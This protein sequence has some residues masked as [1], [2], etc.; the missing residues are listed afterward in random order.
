MVGQLTILRTR[1]S[2]MGE[3]TRNLEWRQRNKEY[4]DADVLAQTL[5]ITAD[6][7]EITHPYVTLDSTA[8]A[9]TLAL[10]NGEPGQVLIVDHKTDG[11]DVDLTPVLATGWSVIALD[12]AGDK[13]ILLYVNDDAGWVIIGLAGAT[14]APL[15]TAA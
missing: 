14:A 9:V 11:G 7:V 6:T 12:D 13:A 3:R 8:G 2:K 4:S 5:V 10:P 15:F 1:R